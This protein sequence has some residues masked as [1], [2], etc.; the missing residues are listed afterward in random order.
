[1]PIRPDQK[2]RYSVDWPQ[3]RAAILDRARRRCERCGVP[4]YAVG[5]RDAE[6]QFRRTAG[7]EWHDLAGAGDL[8]YAEARA[9]VDELNTW[10]GGFGP[11]GEPGIVI[12][13]TIAH[14]PDPAPEN[15]D[16]ANLLALCQRCHNRYD[17]KSRAAG[18]KARRVAAS[19]QQALLEDEG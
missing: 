15:V 13:L 1:M 17:A 12:V 6:G 2:A 18:I 11:N 4:N 5:Y 9:G 8:S 16:P 14:Y 19:A 3:I 7:N 10:G